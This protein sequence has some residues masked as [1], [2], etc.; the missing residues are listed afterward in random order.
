MIR[1]IQL[2]TITFISGFAVMAFE[3]LG[4]RVLFPYFGSSVHI[5]GALIS[6]FLAGL[7]VGYAAGG[8]IA[9]RFQNFPLFS[10]ILLTPSLLM[11]FFPYYGYSFCSLFSSFQ[12]NP[13]WAAL[14]TSTIIFF[15]PCVFSGA[16]VPLTVKMLV[17]NKDQVGSVSGNVYAVA[18]AGSIAGTLFTSFFLIGWTSVKV[19]IQ[20]IGILYAIS[21]ILCLS[22]IG[23]QYFSNIVCTFN[24]NKR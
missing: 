8:R 1:K 23:I 16:I 20:L 22:T 5:W 10:Y 9:D 6:V 7:S 4:S 17:E 14:I 2:L 15:L 24:S 13:K 21:W 12:M 3:I 18:T 19:G 11:I